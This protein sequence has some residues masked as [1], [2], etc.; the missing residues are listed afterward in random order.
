MPGR[1]QVRG[2]EAVDRAAELVD[3]LW[4][5]YAPFQRGRNALG[6]LT[7]MLAI[8]VLAQ[9]A[10]SVGDEDGG[11]VVLWKR[12]T[13]EAARGFSP[14]ADLRAAMKRADGHPAFPLR[15]LPGRSFGDLGFDDASDDVP[16][17]AAYLSAL[18][19]FPPLSPAATTPWAEVSELLI[20]RH[21][22]EGALSAGEYFT[23][24]EV[25]RL[26]VEALAPQSGDRILDPACGSGGFLAAAAQYVAEA[27]GVPGPAIEAY[28]TDHGNQLLATMNLALNGIDQPV[29]RASDPVSLVR[30][31]SSG[32]ADYVLTNPPFNQRLE[33]TSAHAWPFGQPPEA[34]ANFAWLQ[35]AWSRLSD[36]GIAAVLMPPRAAWSES[37]GEDDIRKRMVAA[38]AVLG[39]IA[40]PPNLFAETAV[41]V[42]VWILVRDRSRHL[43]MADGE[44]LLFVDASQLGRQ[45]PRQQRVLTEA[46]IRRIS[47]LFAEWRRSPR[48]VADEPG[49]SRTVGLAEVAGTGFRLDPRLYVESDPQLPMPVADLAV[50]VAGIGDHGGALSRSGAEIQHSFDLCRR[51]A[52]GASAVRRAP[53]RSVVEGS[54]RDGR[55]ES[56][57]S[58]SGSI[59]AGPSGSLIRAEH[60]VDSGGVPVVM[61]KDLTGA[62]I[63]DDSIRRIPE[64]RAAS[65]DR[66]RLQPGDIVLARRGELGRCA[67][68]RDA[69]RGWLCGT[70]CFLLR[71]AGDVD[72]DYLAACLRSPEAREWLDSRST[73]SMTMK[74]IS[75]DVLADLPIALPDPEVQR[76]VARLVRSA[77]AHERQLREGMVMTQRLRDDAIRGLFGGQT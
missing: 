36:S 16:W 20:E 26:M 61:P 25:V 68:V 66:F 30:S 50:L 31:R 53:L 65:L 18:S 74:T 3:R 19:P 56:R 6:D 17:L 23:P 4:R 71:P 69:E 58:R 38:G 42:H 63:S 21:L 22:Q 46:E 39:I 5:S 45:A 10:E 32:L 44:A 28:A 15:E 1:S 29:V 14:L 41:P 52:G 51:L 48:E 34:N 9:F 11:V 2:E 27:G 47:G 40:L 67:V 12:A 76:L 73:G 8:L 37:G 55:E 49:F 59:L 75:L 57:V 62:G 60:Y 33:S 43:P 64:E 7:S 35:L 77:A 72:P 13:R 70:G 24:R 54:L